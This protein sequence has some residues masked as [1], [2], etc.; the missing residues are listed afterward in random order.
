[1]EIFETN[2]SL[3]CLLLL[4]PFFL[5]AQND[6]T[7][8]EVD[9]IDIARKTLGIKE[10]PNKD[11]IKEDSTVYIAVLP[12]LGYAIQTGFTAVIISN[13]S[14]YAGKDRKTNISTINAIAEYS[15]LNQIL[16]PINLN[17]WS[18]G[19]KW[20]FSGDWRYYNYNAFNYGLGGSST[21]SN[22]M[23][24]YYDY[25]RV[26]QLALKRIAHNFLGGI[27]YNLDYH[28]KIREKD[29]ESQ[30]DNHFKNYGNGPQTV[31]SGW[32]ANLLYDIRKNSNA[33]VAGEYFGN[34]IFRDNRT[35][36]G[37]DNNWQSL[38]TDFRT[39]IA[40]PSKTKNILAFW[41]YNIFTLAGKPPYF[42]LPSTGWD[43]YT[44]AARQF[45]Q[46][47]YIGKHL[48]YL[49]TEYRF[50]ISRNGLFNGALF[51]NVQSVA[52][53]P[54]NQFKKI[55]PGIGCGLRTKL[56]KRS[57]VNLLVSYGIATDGSKGFF[58]NLGEVF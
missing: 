57:N 19:N 20:N 53:W 48:M 35:F 40:L 36:L 2:A 28:Y 55:I 58:F 43:S 13:F 23:L 46:G 11:T 16:V 45:R 1:M 7:V 18:K 50:K 41:S 38:F 39:Y 29:P 44:N 3:L 6:S 15:E 37:S 24:V 10:I 30:P 31:S 9:L 8:R 51:A 22:E 25:I 12:A 34:A 4:F 52:E 21:V 47:R 32:S 42:D 17:I 56:N 49:E 54:S 33:P 27:G 5:T 26:Y 14:F